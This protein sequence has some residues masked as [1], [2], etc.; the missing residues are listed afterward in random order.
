MLLSILRTPF[1]DSAALPAGAFF[2]RSFSALLPDA[3]FIVTGDFCV[4]GSRQ[5]QKNLVSGGCSMVGLA[6]RNSLATVGGFLWGWLANAFHPRSVS[7]PHI[8]HNLN[9]N[10]RI[11]L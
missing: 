3:A 9:L 6:Y 11:I 7:N 4:F 8:L 1:P 10:A 2:L 5:I